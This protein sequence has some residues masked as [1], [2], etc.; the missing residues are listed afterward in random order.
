[1]SRSDGGIRCHG[2]T[3][4]YAGGGGVRGVSFTAAPGRVTGLLGPNGSGK[5]TCLKVVL[6]L[7]GHDEGTATI[8]GTPYSQLTSPTRAVG[9]CLDVAGFPPQHTA[10]TVLRSLA[11]RSR[12]PAERV[13]EV[14]GEVE[15]ADVG[16]RRIGQFSLGM[17][18]RL[19]VAAALLAQPHHLVLDEPLNGLDPMGI[20]WLRGLVRRHAEAGGSV[21]LSTHLLT[22]AQLTVDD[23]VILHGGQ[24]LAQAPLPTLVESGPMGAASLESVFFALVERGAAPPGRGVDGTP[25]PA[26]PMTNGGVR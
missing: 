6:G 21:L 16:R 14:L 18:Q 26:T 25:R 19:R 1:M 5:T 22:E 8:D 15:L 12:V 11:V 13:E 9:A 24:V 20:Q 17:V 4:T 10:T 23:V 2:L 7:A 3:K